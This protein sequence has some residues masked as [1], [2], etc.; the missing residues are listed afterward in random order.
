VARLAG[1]VS[2]NSMYGP[3]L[4]DTAHDPLAKGVNQTAQHSDDADC[5]E[6]RGAQEDDYDAQHDQRYCGPR[7]CHT[8]AS[9][10]T[11]NTTASITQNQKK[12]VLSVTAQ[13]PF[14]S[15]GA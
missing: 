3:F 6:Q 8:P 7:H 11:P 2:M 10:G 4:A 13:Y 5:A 12:T 1:V 15:V 14:S 9:T